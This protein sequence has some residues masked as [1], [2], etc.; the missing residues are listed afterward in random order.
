[1]V[2]SEVLRRLV[3]AS[4]AVLPLAFV[5]EIVT[6][7]QLTGIFVGVTI[8]AF[9]LE[10]VRL[11]VGIDW[12]IYR[13][14]TREYEQSNIAGYALYSIGATVTVLAFEPMVAV[15]A[16]FMLMI[17]DPVSGLLGSNNPQDPKRPF[18]LGVTFSLCLVFA[19]AFVPLA[20]AIVGALVATVADGMSPVISGHVIDDNL[21]IPIGAGVGMW[22]VLTYLPL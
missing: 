11:I 5:L 1:M 15:P 19:V 4:G 14:L 10:F 7:R 16:L 9:L 12:W 18:V 22:S 17:A 6:W 21:T 2:R 8:V 13:K 3:H 20:A